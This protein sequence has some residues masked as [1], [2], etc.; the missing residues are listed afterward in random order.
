MSLSN[1]SISSTS[2]SD[3]VALMIIR[4]LYIQCILS[5]F[6]TNLVLWLSILLPPLTTSHSVSY[7]SP[8]TRQMTV[9]PHGNGLLHTP[10]SFLQ[11]RNHYTL[12]PYQQ[13]NAKLQ[14]IPET[15]SARQS[16]IIISSSPPHLILPLS[17]IFLTLCD[18]HCTICNVDV[19]HYLNRHLYFND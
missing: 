3:P 15:V 4:G 18:S 7:T 2:P 11:Y 14:H 16:A 8:C 6:R 5:F 9:I 10:L 12:L 19:P 1:H 13:N 17:C